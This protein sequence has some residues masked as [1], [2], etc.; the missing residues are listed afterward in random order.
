MKDDRLISLNAAIDAFK[1]ELLHGNRDFAVGFVGAK[2]I[3]EGLPSALQWIPCSER[4]PDDEG[5]YLTTTEFG[6]VYCDYWDSIRW[7]RTERVIA[8]ME[9][10]KPWQSK[11]EDG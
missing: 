9:R 2:R 1:K 10:P 5:Y 4:L 3:L 6:G 7:D 11:E 8:W